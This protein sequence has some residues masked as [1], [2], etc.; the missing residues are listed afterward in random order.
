MM[1]KITCY[2]YIYSA[3]LPLLNYKQLVMVI[4]PSGSGKDT[5]IAGAKEILSEDPAFCFI[6]REITRPSGSSSE[7]HISISK[8]EF[9]RR[10]NSGHYAIS[11]QAHGN[12]YGI[13]QSIEESLSEGKLVIFNGSRAVI[14]EAR[15]RFPGVNVIY[16][17]APV[18][19]L[20]ERLNSRGR[21]SHIQVS[22]RVTRNARLNT[23]PDD[24]LVLSNAGS[25]QAALDEFVS[26]LKNL[27]DSCSRQQAGISI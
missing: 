26:I 21:E 9:Q 22:E 12:W 27:R 10:H 20:T 18:S 16:I 25:L 17:D 24:T 19:I 6:T 7:Q 3:G 14:D 23:I 1:V 5:L 2:Q 15:K 4:G 13:V 11:W 8:E